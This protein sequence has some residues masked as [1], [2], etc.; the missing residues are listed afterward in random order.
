MDDSYLYRQ[1][2]E[3]VRRDILEGRLQPGERLPTL[4]EMRET[5]RC[6]QGTAQR[7]Y[8]E[9]AREGLVIS[10]TGRGT[11]DGYLILASL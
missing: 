11:R 1:I 6:T 3:S 4:R 9:L 5:W 2:A 7:A 8:A 10:Q